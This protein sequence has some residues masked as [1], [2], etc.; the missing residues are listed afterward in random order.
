MSY[1]YD[2]SII[3]CT[4]NREQW[5]G[6]AIQSLIDLRTEGGVNYEIVVVP[7]FWLPGET[8]KAP[9]GTG[10]SNCWP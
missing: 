8:L 6:D 9:I 3:L 10:C 4:Y 7:A 2:V 1:Q 5:I